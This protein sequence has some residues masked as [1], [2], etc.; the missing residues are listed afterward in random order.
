MHANLCKE[1]LWTFVCMLAKNV[2]MDWF[3][4]TVS[5]QEFEVITAIP[6]IVKYALLRIVVVYLW[7]CL[8]S[9]SLTVFWCFEYISASIHKILCFLFRQRHI[10]QKNTNK[11]PIVKSYRGYVHLKKWN[12]L[13]NKINL[14]LSAPHIIHKLT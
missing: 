4:G 8:V 1:S 3:K 13:H 7:M 14:Y 5:F 12:N 2:F 9:R 11:K 6:Y 10:Q